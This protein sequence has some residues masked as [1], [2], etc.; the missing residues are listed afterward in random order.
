MTSILMR[1]A[2]LDMAT[3]PLCKRIFVHLSSRY[4]QHSQRGFGLCC[5]KSMGING[6]EQTYGQKGS[7]LVAI[8]ESMVFGQTKTIRCSEARQ[9][10]RAV[11]RQIK[12]TTQGRVQQSVVAQSGR[13]AVLSQTFVMQQQQNLQVDPLPGAHLAS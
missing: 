4:R 12:G 5:Y 3:Y 13:A 2:Q 10:W 9:V 7:T 11:K 1:L 6:E 8:D